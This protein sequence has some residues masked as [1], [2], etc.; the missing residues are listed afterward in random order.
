MPLPTHSSVAS[1]LVWGGGARPP[2]VPTKKITY[3]KLT[4]ARAS[5]SETYIFSGLK[6]ICIHAYTIDAVPF[7]YLWYIALYATVY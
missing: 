2:N 6:I 7:Y 3:M 1:F 5:A 4:I